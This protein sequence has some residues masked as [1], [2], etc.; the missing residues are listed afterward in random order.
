MFP[1]LNPKL[2]IE[3]QPEVQRVA[4]EFGFQYNY[5]SS[6]REAIKSV[7]KQFKKLSVEPGKGMDEVKGKGKKE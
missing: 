7:F 1:S 5:L 3:V 2:L 6:E 4:K